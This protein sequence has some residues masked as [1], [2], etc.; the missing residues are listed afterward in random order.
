[1]TDAI[2]SLNGI[3]L[4]QQEALTKL[5]Q[6]IKIYGTD[7]AFASIEEMENDYYLKDIKN[8]IFFGND[9]RYHCFLNLSGGK[10]K[11][12]VA[13]ERKNLEN[14]IVEL[15]KDKSNV[16]Q[17]LTC[18]MGDIVSNY[19][20]YKEKETCAGTAHKLGWAYNRYVKGSNLETI[21]MSEITTM[22]LKEFCLDQ[23]DKYNLTSKGYKEL[24][25]LLNGL[26][27]YAVDTGIIEH[28]TAKQMSRI[29]TKKLNRTNVVSSTQ[30]FTTEEE[31][32]LFARALEMFAKTSNTSYLAIILSG[33]LGL[34]AGELIA[35]KK[36]DF[37]FVKNE[38]NIQRQEIVNW[39][40]ND[41]NELIREGYQVVDYL[42]TTESK[43]SLPIT[44]SVARVYDLI[45]SRNNFDGIESDYL[46]VYKD[47][48]RKHAST[49]ATAL[50]RINKQLGFVQRSNHKLRKTLLSELENT[51]GLTKTRAFAGH[52][53]NSTTLERNYLYITSPLTSDMS[54]I[55]SVVTERVPTLLKGEQK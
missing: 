20:K 31:S 39:I 32:V 25:S 50:R 14:K 8:S 44:E 33:C 1:M 47:G 34:R 49:V 38:V 3:G 16:C 53:R 10:R 27:D 21:D 11:H 23:I 13:K 12:V 4:S 36:S 29:N 51:I 52:S 45:V 7:C 18:N 35:L 2:K 54:A 37:D 43:R 6:L 5:D 17:T 15:I 42:K 40:K 48:S 24:K 9:E 41:N 28:N 26:F 30:V 22:Q 55:D 19:L 46:F